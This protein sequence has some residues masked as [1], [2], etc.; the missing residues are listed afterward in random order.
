LREP[1]SRSRDFT[2]VN[3]ADRAPGVQPPFFRMQLQ[4]R[5]AYRLDDA[6]QARPLAD[7]AGGELQT[8][9]A[10]AGI[11]N[12]ARFFGM[13]KNAGLTFAEMPLPD[14]YDFTINPFAAV[15]ADVILITEKDAVKCAR[16]PA[17]KNDPRL[18]VVPVEAQL[19]GMLLDQILEKLRGSSPA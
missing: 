9:V 14:H 18:W 4:G 3:G 10:A 17:L 15:T 6:A 16:S 19:D 5:V 1:A 7:F 2:I 12:P 11:G 13:L 8:I